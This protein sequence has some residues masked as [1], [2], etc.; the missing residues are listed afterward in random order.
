MKVTK[1]VIND[2]IE[3]CYTLATIRQ[4]LSG[5]NRFERTNILKEQGKLTDLEWWDYDRLYSSRQWDRIELEQQYDEEFESEKEYYLEEYGK[6][7]TKPTKAMI[8]KYDELFG[9][10]EKDLDEKLFDYERRI[11][12]NYEISKGDNPIPKFK[13]ENYKHDTDGIEDYSIEDDGFADMFYTKYNASR[14]SIG[15]VENNQINNQ[16]ENL[17]FTPK[18]FSWLKQYFD[19]NRLPSF[20]TYMVHNREPKQY[21]DAEHGEYDEVL[22]EYEYVQFSLTD[23]WKSEYNNIKR[24]LDNAIN[25][26]NGLSQATILYHAGRPDPKLLPGDHGTWK[27]YKSMS[28][29]QQVMQKHSNINDD[30]WNMIVLAPKG[31]KGVCAND[32]RFRG[33]SFV[34]EHEYLLGRNTG[35]TVVSTDLD[36][37]TQI[38]ILD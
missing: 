16:S 10:I 36:T 29:Q 14:N 34:D 8:R 30:Y 2:I 24:H 19:D 1:A 9:E 12:E 17:N 37:H 22:G 7:L 4:K 18:E 28:F 31:T 20:L 35:Y 11:F 15:E 33:Y 5:L 3:K 6:E 27:G 23:R 32:E 26:S 21:T 25:K 13:W 38:I